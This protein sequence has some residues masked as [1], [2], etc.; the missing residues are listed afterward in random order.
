MKLKYISELEKFG[1]VF[2]SSEIQLEKEFEKYKLNI[3]PEKFHSLLSFAQLYIGEGGSTASEATILGT[4]SIH[5]SSTAKFCG[6]FDEL[7]RYGLIY[8]FSDDEEA[9]KK[10]V[11]ILQNPDS[12]NE[13]KEKKE[14]LL[15]EKI[16]VV[17]FMTTMIESYHKG[18]A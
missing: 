15:K 16:D 17:K 3:S 9:L 11:A 12:K 2:I 8:T 13:W 14:K 5:I 1:R 10:A 4:P 6:N 18:K 7:Y